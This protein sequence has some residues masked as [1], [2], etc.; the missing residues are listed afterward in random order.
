MQIN[1]DYV[2][3]S[4]VNGWEFLKY[5]YNASNVKLSMFNVYFIN[6]MFYG[7]KH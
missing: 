7:N 4:M 2:L 3:F 5:T 6:N 1:M